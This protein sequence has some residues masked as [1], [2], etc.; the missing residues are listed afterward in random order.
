M[1]RNSKLN[2]TTRIAR[3]LVI[4]GAAALAGCAGSQDAPKPQ[5]AATGSPADNTE[6]RMLCE[7]DQVDRQNMTDA[8]WH[9]VSKRDVAR[10][11]RVREMLAE[12]TVNTGAD[13]YHAALI[14][15]HSMDVEGIQL[16]HELSMISAA[17]GDKRGRWLMAASYDRLLNRL[18]QPQRFGTQYRQKGN[19]PMSLGEI[20]PGVTDAMRKAINVPTLEEA[21]AREEEMRRMFAKPEVK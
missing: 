19:E 6:L 13:Y 2:R 8:D 10:E 9:E 14:C 11:A 16:A 4:A 5:P 17:L 18:D 7:A 15:Q 12:G 20:S 21:K 1:N 3:R